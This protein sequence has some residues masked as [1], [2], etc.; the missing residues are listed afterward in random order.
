MVIINIDFDS[1]FPDRSKGYLDTQTIM[2]NKFNDYHV[3]VVPVYH[4]DV[5]MTVQ[6]FHEKDFTEVQYEELKKIIS[7]SMN[8]DNK[9]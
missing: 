8:A 3:L 1:I 7:N 2:E 9:I 6:V 5:A 4:A